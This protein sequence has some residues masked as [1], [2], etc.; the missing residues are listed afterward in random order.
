MGGHGQFDVHADTARVFSKHEVGRFPEPGELP[1]LL[2][3]DGDQ[4]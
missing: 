3:G 2:A 4:T 1:L